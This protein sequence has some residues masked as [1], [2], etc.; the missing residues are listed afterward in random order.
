MTNGKHEGAAFRA[1]L[2]QMRSARS[3][4][5]NRDVAVGLIEQAKRDGA[6]YVQ[7]PE[8]TNIM[9]VKRDN[10]FA[11]IVAEEQDATLAAFRDLARR[12]AIWVH[13][14]S[15]AVKVSP[16][17]A[18]NRS[19]LIDPRGDIKARYD[20]I[21]MFDVDLAG[22]ESYRESNA[23]RPGERAVVAETPWGVLGMTVCYDLRF[24]QLYRSLAKAGADFLAIPSSFTVPTGRAH[25]HTLMRARA[26]ENGCFVL[27]PAQWGEHAE[28]RRTYGH[29][30]IVDPWGEVLAEGGE[31]VGI[32]TAKID[33]SRIA[34]VRGGL[35]SLKH[36]RDF[37]SPEL[38][39]R[40]LAA[41]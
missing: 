18:A 35:P 12:L 10:L 15:L 31:G 2:I 19:F 3:P 11:A 39:T 7:T 33:P 30:L 24:P 34:K 36:D 26:I 14:G 28:R 40:P 16:D 13:A 4:A 32:I 9:E 21:H 23:F 29:S 8:M 25:W 37:T 6:D 41:E 22:G 27:A 17:R 1:G 5:E 38:V 20:K